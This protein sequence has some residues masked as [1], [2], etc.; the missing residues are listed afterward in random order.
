MVDYTETTEQRDRGG[1]GPR[2]NPLHFGT[3]WIKG[4]YQGLYYHLLLHFKI[5]LDLDGEKS[6]YL[7]D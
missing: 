1:R 4:A 3:N 2:K 7:G 6:G 5:T